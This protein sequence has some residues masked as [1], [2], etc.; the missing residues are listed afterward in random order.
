MLKR[1][2]YVLEQL[3]SPLVVYTTP[4]HEELKAIARDCITRHHAHHYLGFAATQWKL[5]EKESPPRVKPLLYTFRVLLTGI[6]LMDTGEVE[7][8]LRILNQNA[9]LSYVDELIER[10][11]TGAEQGVLDAA[12]VSFYRKEYDRLTLELETRHAATKLPE[13]PTGSAAL[14]D[15]LVRLRLGENSTR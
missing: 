4:E 10:K 14:N 2:G 1:N 3:L 13:I 11:L 8:N 9:K 6:H 7:A 15:L 12:D 5:F